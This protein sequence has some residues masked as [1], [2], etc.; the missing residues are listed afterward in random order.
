MQIKFEKIKK[1]TMNWIK[2]RD[3][4][5]KINKNIKMFMNK[6]STLSLL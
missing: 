3:K 6:S 4:M 5:I 1:K 2:Q